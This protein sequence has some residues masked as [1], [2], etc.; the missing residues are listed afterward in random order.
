[1]TFEEA[2]AKHIQLWNEI[3]RILETEDTHDIQ[4]VGDLKRQALHNLELSS[5]AD[6]D[7]DLRFRPCAYCFACEYVYMNCTKCPITWGPGLYT[8]NEDGSL[9]QKLREIAN[10]GCLLTRKDLAIALAKEIRDLPWANRD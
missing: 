2:H 4:N 6:T 5:F 7:Y 8:C 1:M 3:V 9:Y 10:D